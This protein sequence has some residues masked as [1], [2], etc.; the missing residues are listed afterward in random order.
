MAQ[1]CSRAN[2]LE[3]SLVDQLVAV[4]GYTRNLPFLLQL[5]IDAIPACSV[6]STLDDSRMR[7]RGFIL[8]ALDLPLPLN[9]SIDTTQPTWSMNSLDQSI[10]TTD[11]F[12]KYDNLPAY[13]VDN[14]VLTLG[15]T[16]A[17]AFIQAA[18]CDIK[19]YLASI[20]SSARRLRRHLR[21]R[22]LP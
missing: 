1:L 18:A 6:D 7:G 11:V 20:G 14:E 22:R 15:A 21:C 5:G 8:C 9:A 3:T 17:A 19:A 4:A 2:G 13:N 12:S 10:D 16:N